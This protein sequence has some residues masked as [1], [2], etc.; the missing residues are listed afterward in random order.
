MTRDGGGRVNDWNVAP[1]VKGG[2]QEGLH[3]NEISIAGAI[4]RMEPRIL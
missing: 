2:R 3:Y 4:R 1:D